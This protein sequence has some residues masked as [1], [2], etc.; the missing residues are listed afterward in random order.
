MTG[1]AE[2]QANLTVTQLSVVPAAL[3]PQ[4]QPP[5]IPPDFQDVMSDPELVSVEDHVPS[6]PPLAVN[7]SGD[8]ITFIIPSY[9]TVTKEP[10]EEVWLAM[11]GNND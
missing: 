8:G 5:V 9:M 1:E 6:M 4:P 10:Q 3:P 7:S 2:T 11:H